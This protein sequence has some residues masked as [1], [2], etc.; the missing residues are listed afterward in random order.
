ML[1]I[2]LVYMVYIS[3]M[4]SQLSVLLYETGYVRVYEL[5]VCRYVCTC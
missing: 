3:F 5:T 2:F 1:C 4:S